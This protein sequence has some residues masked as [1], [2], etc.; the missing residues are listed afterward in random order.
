MNKIY[1]TILIILFSLSLS[2]QTVDLGFPIGWKGKLNSKNIPNVSMSGYNQALMDSEDAVNDISKDRPW[3]FGYKYDVNYTHQNSGSWTILPNG[4]RVWQLA[5]ECNNALTINLLFENY[6]LPEG[7]YIYLYDVDHTNKVGAYTAKNNR[8]DG[9]LGTELVHGDNIIIEYVEP[10]RVK[11]QGTFTISS[12]VHG[13]RSLNTI[14]NS[15][16]KA[17]NS[18]G[19]CNID[20]N[21]PLG[22]G[23]DNEI[24]SVA[25]IVVNGSGICTGAL[26]NNT[27]NDGTPYFLTANHCLGGGTGS[28]AFRFNWQSPPG[29]ESCATTSNSVDPGPPYDQTAN[30]A[31]TLVSSA[32]SDFALLEID[33]MT[34]TDAQNWNCYYAGWDASDDPNAVTEATGIHHPSGDVKKICR[35]NNIPYHSSAGGAA[36][37]YI[38]QW[39]EGVTEPGS[40]GSPLFDQNHRII[41]QLYGGLAAC[42]GTVNNGD[43]DYYGRVGVSWNNGLDSYLAPNSCGIATT[44]DG[45]DPNTPTLPDDAGISGISSPSGAYCVDN[46]DPEISLRNYGTNNLNNVTIYYDL[47]GGTQNTFNWTGNLTPGATE[48]IQFGNMTTTS[49]AHTF[50]AVTSLPNGNPDSNPLNDGAN[51]NYT[52]TIGGQDIQIEIN[53]DCWG[54]EITWTIEDINSNV[55]ASGG[56]YG[57]VAG[58]ELILTNIC[59]AVDCYDFII[60]DSYGD[61]MYGSQWGSCS[62]DGDYTILDVSSGTVLASIIAANSDFGNQEINNFCVSL[63]CPWSA[64]S[65][66]T[67]E[68]CFGDSTGSINVSATGAT[69]PFTYN[70]GNGPQNS[71]LFNNLS[72]GNYSVTVSDGACTS[73]VQVALLGPTEISGIIS[74]TDVSCNGLS[75]GTLS[76][77]GS[78]GDSTYTYDFGSGFSSNGTITGLSAG[79]QSVVVQDGNGCI[80]TINGTVSQPS[81]INVSTYVVDETF[82]SDGVINITVSGGVP[83]FS[84]AWNGPSGYTSTNED[85]GGLTGGSYFLTVTDANGC[86]TSLNDILV[87]SFVGIFENG[88]TIFNIYPN[89]SKGIFNVQFNDKIIGV[90]SI[91]IFDLTGRL[92][93]NTVLN[94]EK[95]CL[96]DISNKDLGTYVL[97]I[98][99]NEN[100]YIKRITNIK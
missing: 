84:F 27:C 69:G 54:S 98:S 15:L 51:S 46:F 4:N 96:I 49:G 29:T 65:S 38:D 66:T 40:S 97:K 79:S 22:N 42:S 50:N 34:L 83:P 16:A 57:D 92:V 60:N 41:G 52:A 82:G 21:C 37:W 18:S 47:D 68:I 99:V 77:I 44:D 67:E 100:H 87:D 43:Y 53:T 88:Q 3:R 62:V 86:T 71:G 55:L 28:W 56:P 75:D 64:T 48:I 73:I 31:T 6:N 20:V 2:S 32:A 33:N 7:A 45:W 35:E 59:L 30:G 25:M 74:T 17:L 78:G 89:P 63:P 90:K 26:I 24:N 58:G 13:Y 14:Q 9:L 36:V 93:Y 19:D 39:E 23:W 80:G 95:V 10:A 91:N 1:S 85:I 76:V 70:I 81:T 94:N 5:I 72:Q 8:I 11:F 12:I 61:G